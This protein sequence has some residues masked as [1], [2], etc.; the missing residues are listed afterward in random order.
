VSTEE[1][2]FPLLFF[3]FSISLCFYIIKNNFNVHFTCRLI[4]AL[5]YIHYIIHTTECIQKHALYGRF[6][7]FPKVILTLRDFWFTRRLPRRTEVSRTMESHLTLTS[8][9]SANFFA[10]AKTKILH[11]RR[12]P[13]A[14]SLYSFPC[15]QLSL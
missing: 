3:H 5:Y 12:L 1:Y 15:F 7:G 13:I 4:C 10:T 14:I 6:K 8:R 11:Y 9:S 2:S